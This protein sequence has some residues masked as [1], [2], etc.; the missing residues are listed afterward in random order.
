LATII[1]EIVHGA[2]LV[3]AV[4]AARAVLARWPGAGE[5]LAAIDAAVAAARS[6]PPSPDVVEELGAGWVAEE[7]LGIAIYCALVAGGDFAAGLRLAVNHSGDSDSTG[8]ITG[9]ILGTL[10]GAGAI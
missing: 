7:A 8:A 5:C 9:N 2:S 3:D 6:G 4:A 10:L 1:Q